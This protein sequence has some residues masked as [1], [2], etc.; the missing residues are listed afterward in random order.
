MMDADDTG[1][2]FLT[3]KGKR[4]Y[5]RLVK[6]GYMALTGIKG[7]DTLSCVAVSMRGKVKE[8]GDGLLP[9]LFDKNPYMYEIYPTEASRSALTVFKMHEG[10]GEWFDLS[11]SPIERVSFTFGGAKEEAAGYF[12]TD[13]CTGCKKCKSVCPQDC[14]DFSALPAVIGQTHCLHCGNCKSVCPAGAVEKRG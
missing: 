9:Q 4:F 2:Y 1:L 6:R 8:I 10:S 13:K 14:I 7:S 3:A 5:D 11:K 12:I